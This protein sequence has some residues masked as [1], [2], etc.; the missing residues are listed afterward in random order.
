[1][2]RTPIAAKN[3]QG[4]TYSEGYLGH[5]SPDSID[6]ILGGEDGYRSPIDLMSRTPSHIRFEDIEPASNQLALIPLITD[7]LAEKE[8]KLLEA[9]AVIRYLEEQMRT[10]DKPR[11]AIVDAPEQAV[12][13]ARQDGEMS[14][15]GINLSGAPAPE[16]L[17]RT[18]QPMVDS[19]HIVPA[20]LT[21]VESEL[22]N[23]PLIVTADRRVPVS[24]YFSIVTTSSEIAKKFIVS[25][26]DK[27]FENLEMLDKAL[28]ASDLLSLVDG[29]RKRPTPTADNMTGYLADAL[30]MTVDAGGLPSYIVAA[31]DDCYKYYKESIVAFTFMMSMVHKDM[32]HLLL[33][34]I[35][36]EDPVQIYRAIQEHFKGGK[37][38]HVEAARKKLND[39]R[40]G[41]DIERDLST[42]LELFSS[43]EEAQGMVMPES[44]KFGILRVLMAQEERVHDRNIVGIA[45]YNKE[46]FNFTIKKIREE[47]DA[48]PMNKSNVHMATAT[49]PVTSN[50]ICF[51]FQTN[52]CTREGFPYIHKIMNDQ[53]KKD[54]KYNN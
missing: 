46:N 53:E 28:R 27:N 23:A 44:Q 26:K 32:H 41:Q 11:N 37:S 39:H 3:Q 17:P 40:L 54:Q 19:H 9:L 14:T 51:K 38:H 4:P 35:R 50:R 12:S 52:E 16:E 36:K 8:S 34:L 33:D 48:I 42:L 31:A 30:I 2:A 22:D 5:Q 21:K 47:W 25:H 7:Q 6:S 45:S 13:I 10:A 1:M 20:P 43:L 49:E 24:K 29:S 15:S 18:G